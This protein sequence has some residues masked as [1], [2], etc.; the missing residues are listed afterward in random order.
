MR[1]RVGMRAHSARRE[2]L[3][4]FVMNVER[5]PERC[6]AWTG[7]TTSATEVR[8]LRARRDEPGGSKQARPPPFILFSVSAI[9]TCAL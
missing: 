8:F 1:T 3:S 6:P 7:R 2:I 5:R 9:R 4:G